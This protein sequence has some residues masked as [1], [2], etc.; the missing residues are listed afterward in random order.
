MSISISHKKTNYMLK[1]NLT[2]PKLTWFLVMAF[3]SILS[4]LQTWQLSIQRDIR[5][6]L[7]SERPYAVNSALMLYSE[8][9]T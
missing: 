5:H 3:S 6:T 9:P 4:W 8:K 7:C 1:F 2:E